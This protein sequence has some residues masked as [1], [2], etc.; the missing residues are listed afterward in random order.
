MKTPRTVD[1]DD[2]K[3]LAS[4]SVS[5][6]VRAAAVILGVVGWIRAAEERRFCQS[7]AQDA[8]LRICLQDSTR[9]IW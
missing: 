8:L 5:K 3:K 9:F 4:L 2:T 6:V 1:P 7:A